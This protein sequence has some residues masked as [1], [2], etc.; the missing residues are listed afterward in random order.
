M[1]SLGEFEQLILFAVLQLGDE[2]Y[3][4]AIRDAIE[5]RTGRT[6]SS[7]AIYTTLGRLEERGLVRSTIDGRERGRVGR[8]RKYYELRPAGARALRDSYAAIQAMADGLDARLAELAE[9]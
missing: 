9:G 5:E 4:L 2:A 3:G 7:G 8:P 1:G 6:V